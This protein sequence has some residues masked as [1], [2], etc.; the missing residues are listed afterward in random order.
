L[1]EE[2]I[3]EVEKFQVHPLARSRNTPVIFLYNSEKKVY[4]KTGNRRSAWVTERDESDFYLRNSARPVFFQEAFLFAV[5]R[6]MT[7]VF[8]DLA[9]GMNL[10]FFDL[11]LWSPPP[12][13]FK[14]REF[15]LSL[16]LTLDKN[17]AVLSHL[18]LLITD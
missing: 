12:K 14:W 10:N 6:N 7:G 17:S 15:D 16:D 3:R 11:A 8:L 5:I 1:E 13:R 2:T 18:L 9:K 4:W